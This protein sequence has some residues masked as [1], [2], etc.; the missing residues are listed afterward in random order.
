[1][2]KSLHLL[3]IAVLTYLCLASPA[4]GQTAQQF[5][6]SKEK[7]PFS[8]YCT[9]INEF[10]ATAAAHKDAGGKID[11]TSQENQAALR[12]FLFVDSVPD[13]F[14]SLLGPVAATQGAVAAIQRAIDA[15][16]NS[17][18]KTSPVSLATLTATNQ[19]R[20][21]QQTGAPTNTNGTT[22]LV[23]KAGTASV[24]AFALES[25]ALTR[26]VNGN[27]ATLS[28]NA[29]GLLRALTGQQVLCFDC[30]GA[31]GTPILRN[32][33]LSAAFMINQE[34]TSTVSTNGAANSSTPPSITGVVI[35][36]SVGKLSGVTARYQVW[37]P[38]DPHSSKFLAAWKAAAADAKSQLT[39]AQQDLQSRLGVL[40]KN[41]SI[42]SDPVFLPT[43]QTYADRIYADADAEDLPRLKQDFLD[44]FNA[45]VDDRMTTDPQFLQ[46]VANVNVSLGQ[47]KDLWNQLLTAAKGQPLL[48]FEYAFSRPQS[49]PETHDFRLVLG[50]TP[51]NGTGLLS[52][53][54]AVSVYGSTIPAGAKYGRLHDG[55]ISAEYDRPFTI[56]SNPNQATFSLAAYWQ[57]QPDPSVLN[58]TA[59]NLAP[60]TN[61]QLPQ[62]AQVLLGTAGSLW[63]TQAK[64][65]INGKSGIK[66]PI[67]VSWSNK[68]DLL[69]GNKVGAQ[70]GI[71]YD[72]SSLSSLFGGSK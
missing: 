46:N 35:P 63:V 54:A 7:D 70:V 42:Q 59:G 15:I 47:Y 25:G 13:R 28:G 20:P 40:L 67:G 50:Y 52:V 55:Q 9:D 30:T 11:R 60:G 8:S 18:N 39:N 45:S 22:G 26:S 43:L 16:P 64:I 2:R 32:I 33:N 57:Y 53:N 6:C 66:I 38:Y 65:T 62:N 68:T 27:T 21:D 44:L 48:T 23:E 1:M 49:Q 69:A 34:S 41:G 12:S 17:P 58:I 56:R 37:N 4:C 61:I 51:K 14:T 3:T 71:S 24:L 31:N 19:N 36:S 29:D 72:F 5:D 10:L